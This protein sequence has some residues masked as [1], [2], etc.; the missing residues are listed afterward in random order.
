MVFLIS[1]NVWLA[2]CLDVSLLADSGRGFGGVSHQ[3]YRLFQDAIHRNQVRYAP[4]AV[5]GLEDCR[6]ELT[7]ILSH[8]APRRAF[9]RERTKKLSMQ[10]KRRHNPGTIKIYHPGTRP[11]L[12]VMVFAPKTNA[13]LVIQLTISLSFYDHNLRI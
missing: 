10:M 13:L 1:M 3:Q 12:C 9:D 4:G 11:G 7:G 6:I 5:M 8:S 2:F